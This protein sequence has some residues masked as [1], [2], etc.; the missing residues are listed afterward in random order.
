MKP[1]ILPGPQG[2]L[3]G[4]VEVPSSKSLT[5]RALIAAAVAGGG[6]ILDPLDCDDTRILSNGLSAAGW[7]IEWEDGITV[8]GRTVPGELTE[9]DLG[10]SG[11][12]SRLILALLAASP[13]RSLVD[14][15]SRLR[16]R[17][18]GPLLETL[19]ALGAGLSHRNGFLPVK[20]EGCELPGGE[21]TITPENS[22]QYISALVLAAP[23]MRHGLDLQVCGPFPSAPYLGLTADVLRAFGGEVE[24]S[25]DQR[26]WQIGSAPL[27]RT[28][29]RVEGDWSAAAFALAA[30]AG[31][32]GEISISNV[33]KASGQGDRA[34]LDI[35][36]RAGLQIS[37][38]TGSLLVRGPVTR[39]IEADLSDTPDL[40]PALATVAGAIAP[41]SR[42]RGLDHLK[43]KESDRLSVMTANLRRLGAVV[44][45]DDSVFTVEETMKTGFPKPP[46]VTAANDHRIA[47][48]MAVAAL[49]AGPLELDD[50]SCV[51]KSFPGFWDMWDGLLN[52]RERR[53]AQ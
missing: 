15:S 6:R 30:V 9:L 20:V 21:A 42:L 32:G 4:S 44:N 16:E 40:F 38:R 3:V 47:M 14:G 33:E 48:S 37:E 31:V 35:L 41:G 34:I 10:D 46:K 17:P 23:L 49:K 51:A 22:S 39:A 25:G 53:E 8:G 27:E 5:N 26:R 36:Q 24:V 13:G 2:D 50:G 1:R 11:T 45:V 7:D 12:G 29:Y 28:S 19:E 43:H 18:M 52:G